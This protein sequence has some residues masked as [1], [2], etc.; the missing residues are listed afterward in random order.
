MELH[1]N[2]FKKGNDTMTMAPLKP[3]QTPGRA[4]FRAGLVKARPSFLKPEPGPKPEIL[5]I[6]KPEPGPK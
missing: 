5:L 6:F 2:T 3:G 1:G 4:G